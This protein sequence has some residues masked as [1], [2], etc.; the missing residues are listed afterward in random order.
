LQHPSG[1]TYAASLKDISEG[2]QGRQGKFAHGL[3]MKPTASIF[4]TGYA[5]RSAHTR[6]L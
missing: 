1:R 6:G 4:A 5:G 2:A 3:K